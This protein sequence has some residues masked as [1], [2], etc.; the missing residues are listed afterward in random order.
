[1]LHH[2]PT[3]RFAADPQR[4]NQTSC[5]RARSGLNRV[6]R[7]GGDRATGSGLLQRPRSH[8]W[9][10]LAFYCLGVDLV[11]GRLCLTSRSGPGI[12][13]IETMS[14]IQLFAFVILPAVIA[15]L[16]YLI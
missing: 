3:N 7:S 1:M 10:L 5:Q 2:A 12:E 8:T 4:E 16:G 9:W 13:R 15:G 6:H 14:G 11:Y